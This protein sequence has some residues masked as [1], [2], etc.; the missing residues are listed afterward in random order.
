MKKGTLEE[1]KINDYFKSAALDELEIL[2][3]FTGPAP[4]T[5]FCREYKGLYAQDKDFQSVEGAL[6][7]IDQS[8]GYIEALVGGSRFTSYNQLNRAMQSYRQA[9]SS[10]KPLLYAAAMETKKFTPAS[11]IL[12]SPTI[13]L[14]FEGG[15]WVP[16][17]YE[18]EYY[19]MVR[20][21]DA[22]TRSINVVSIQIAEKLKIDTVL[23]YY[24]RLL[25]MDESTAKR[26]IQRNL[27]IALG[28]VEVSPL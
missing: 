7:S 23:T 22:L 14:D 2:N 5:D 11:T 15:S 26:R 17:N 13:F 6:I 28:S 1:K 21:R 24:R 16:E 25:R 8:N 3:F 10:I 12:D 9:G 27:S 20:L 19:G 4:V 18:G